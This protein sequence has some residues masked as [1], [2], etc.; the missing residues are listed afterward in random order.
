MVIELKAGKGKDGALGQL[1]QGS[2]PNVR[3]ILVAS[4]FDSRVIFAARGLYPD[5]A[6]TA[7]N[8]AF[9]Y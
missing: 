9:F 4:T 8:P 6:S 5:V 2:E 1:S 3:G 7:T